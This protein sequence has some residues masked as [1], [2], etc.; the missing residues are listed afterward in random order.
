M[1][2]V[3]IRTNQAVSPSSSDVERGIDKQILATCR[4]GETVDLN[5]RGALQKDLVLLCLSL[6]HGEL[7]LLSLQL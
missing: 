2:C 3:P 5:V 1:N 7:G 4:K 6:G